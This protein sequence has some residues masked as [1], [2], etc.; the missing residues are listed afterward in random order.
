MARAFGTVGLA[1]TTKCEKWEGRQSV[2]ITSKEFE[3]VNTFLNRTDC[4]N[5]VV[6]QDDHTLYLLHYRCKRKDI[7]LCD[8][9]LYLYSEKTLSF[10]G[11]LGGEIPLPQVLHFPPQTITNFFFSHF[12]FPHKQFQPSSPKNYI[13]RKK[14]RIR[15]HVLHHSVRI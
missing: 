2:R 7:V 5:M 6:S 15:Q 4:E 3:N 1:C 11:P 12:L 8:T 9:N 13:S 14:P 10:S